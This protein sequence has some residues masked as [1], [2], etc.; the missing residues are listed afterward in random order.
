MEMLI[1]NG[2]V[3]GGF[4]FLVGY[5]VF[6]II[7]QSK[8]LNEIEMTSVTPLSN[9]VENSSDVR[10]LGE[11]LYSAAYFMQNDEYEYESGGFSVIESAGGSLEIQSNLTLKKSLKFERI[12]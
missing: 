9:I 3:C 5:C 2:I 10:L 4:G 8:D 12:S 7:Q 11:R 6:A 1:L